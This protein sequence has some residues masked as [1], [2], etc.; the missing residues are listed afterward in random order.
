MGEAARHD[1]GKAGVTRVLWRA[2]D[3]AELDSAEEFLTQQQAPSERESCGG[4]LRTLRGGEHLDVRGG[5]HPV[6]LAMMGA[7]ALGDG[8]EVGLDSGPGVLP[9]PGSSAGAGHR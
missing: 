9:V 2:G 6:Y 8:V 3:S 7:A 5:H 1:I 4:P